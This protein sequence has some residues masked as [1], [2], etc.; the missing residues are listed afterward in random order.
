MVITAKFCCSAFIPDPMGAIGL[1]DYGAGNFTSVFNALRF[2]EF[3]VIR[4]TEPSQMNQVSHLILPGVGAF[5][6][7]MRKLESLHLVEELR[8][9]LL[10]NQKPFLGICVG[11]QVLGSLGRE[12]ENYP[13]LGFVPGVVDLIPADQHGLR[14]P[15][16]GWNELTVTRPSPLFAGMSDKPIFYFV[17][18]YQ[19][20]PESPENVL[21]TCRYGVE[22]VAVVERA[23]IFGVQF[24]PEKSQH[25]GLRLLRNFA[26]LPG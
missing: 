8:R 10:E 1:I 25:D 2:L 4:V 24:H 21:A 17:H 7:A 6:T 18:S 26:S 22:V 23:N 15:H 14:L 11:M 5:P 9:Q 3:D 19:L 20:R 16:I 13:G 12:F